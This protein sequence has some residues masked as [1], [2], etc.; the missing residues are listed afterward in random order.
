MRLTQGLF[1][2]TIA[3]LKGKEREGILL[4]HVDKLNPFCRLL[5]TDPS[6]KKM[7]ENCDY[8]HR[9]EVRK[10][11]RSLS[12]TCHTGLTDFIIPIL[13]EGTIIAYLQC[14]QVLN[15][16]PT[17]KQWKKIRTLYQGLNVDF[18]ALKK[19]FFNTKVLDQLGTCILPAGN[20]F[21]YGLPSFLEVRIG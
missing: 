1:G 18:R 11:K 2:I 14:G 8:L 15:E 7:C 6:G 10:F 16:K 3:L 17:N 5:Q 12:Y 9:E 21:M 20:E 4:G 19:H 13:V